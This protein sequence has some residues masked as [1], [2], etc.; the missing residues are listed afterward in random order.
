MK[1][2]LLDKYGRS[3][4]TLHEAAGELC[5][6]DKAVLKLIKS[7]KLSAI[8]FGSTD[9]RISIDALANLFGQTS[10]TEVQQ[11]R[12]K[13]DRLEANASQSYHVTY[14][15]GMY[16]DYTEEDEHEMKQSVNKKSYGNG[17]VFWSE[18]RKEWRAQFTITKD[19]AKKRKLLTGFQ[20]E[21]DAYKSLLLAQSL[22]NG[23]I[24]LNDYQG[25]VAAENKP[26]NLLFSEH[27]QNYLAFIEGRGSSRAFCD[28]IRISKV[29]T[30]KLGHYK[31]N[32]LN[33]ENLSRFLQ[34]YA[35]MHYTKGSKKQ[36]YSQS[37]INKVYDNLNC[38]IRFA[39]KKGLIQQNPMEFVEKPETRQHTEET[40]AALSDDE[41]CLILKAV[42]NKPMMHLLILILMNT[43]IDRILHAIEEYGD[44]DLSKHTLQIQRALSTQ[45]NIDIVTKKASKPVPRIK[46]LKNE[47]KGKK[48]S[49]A[50]RTIKLSHEVLSAVQTY[51]KM[52]QDNESLVAKRKENGT[53]A[54]LFTAPTDGK[55]KTP[56]Y[57]LQTYRKELAKNGLDAKVYNMYRL[58]HNFCTRLIRDHKLDIKTVARMMGDSS[59]DMVMRVYQSVNK[60]DTLRGSAEFSQHIC[61]ILYGNQEENY[62]G[63]L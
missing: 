27:Y 45:S 8:P 51:W 9:A 32:E 18:S 60:D 46:D 22:E 2:Y 20:S 58:R 31:L 34:D 1:N 13:P 49:V 41:L 53:Q 11:Q 19:G 48:S 12:K 3:V 44:F 54:Y 15:D 6:D 61:Q 40:Y 23:E 10:G 42:Q 37:N 4:L 33:M 38:C 28:K 59:I 55:I 17:S 47:R 43:G 5:L 21:A 56:D 24:Q 62:D 7:G 29:I 30:E 26:G 39:L 35:N 16:S 52:I 14:R 50:R 63:R 25:A 36:F 57:Y